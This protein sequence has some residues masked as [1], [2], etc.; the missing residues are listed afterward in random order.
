MRY[1]QR[2]LPSRRVSLW[3]KHSKMWLLI[4][5]RKLTR[6]VSRRQWLLMRPRRSTILPSL[7]IKHTWSPSSR[8]PLSRLRRT[9]LWRTS[10]ICK[11]T[12]NSWNTCE[13]R[14]STNSTK[15]IYSL[16]L[17][18]RLKSILELMVI[19]SN[20]ETPQLMLVQSQETKKKTKKQEIKKQETR[21]LAV[22]EIDEHTN[23]AIIFRIKIRG[24][25]HGSEQPILP[26]SR[27][28]CACTLQKVSC[29]SL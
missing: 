4:C 26:R 12:R 21:R 7:P 11:P 19:S 20:K 24:V 15:R 8:S 2:M 29:N 13:W 3:S 25:R 5:R 6:R 17:H 9:E 22:F 10:W 23:T 28:L 14:R 18:Q 27:Y 1:R 16:V